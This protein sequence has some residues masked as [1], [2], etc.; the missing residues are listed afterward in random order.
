MPL[1]NF[2]AF[3]LSLTLCRIFVDHFVLNFVLNFACRA[4]WSRRSQAEAEAGRRRVPSVQ[5]ISAN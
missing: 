5:K 2:L 1:R 4:G 3:S